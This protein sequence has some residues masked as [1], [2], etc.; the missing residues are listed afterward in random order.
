LAGTEQRGDR[1]T[2][3]VLA[4]WPLRLPDG[5]R[6]SMMSAVRVG[7]LL[8]NVGAA[9]SPQSIVEFAQTAEASGVA[10][11]W[12]G[13]HLLL[14]EQ[15]EARYPYND[16]GEYVVPSDRNFLDAFTTLAW[17]AGQTTAARLGVSV[18]IAPYR[19]PAQVAKVLGTL[20]FLAP[21]RVVFGVGT[22][23][24]RDEFD[25]LAVP[26]EDRNAATV[27][28][29]RFLR[30]AGQAEGPVT[31]DNVGYPSHRM[32]LRP[33]PSAGLP[34]W[35][36]G[37]G[38]LAR[39]RAARHGDAW[40]PALHR[41]SPAELAEQFDEVKALAVEA[42]RD[43]DSI[44]LTLF[45]GVALSDTWRERP[46]E[47]GMVRGPAEPVVETL[48]AYAEAGVSEFV[49]SIGGLDA[50]AVGDAR[51]ARPGGP[52]LRQPSGSRPWLIVDRPE[53]PTSTAGRR[54]GRLRA[55]RRPQL[56]PREVGSTRCARAAPS[57]RC[58]PQRWTVAAWWSSRMWSANSLATSSPRLVTW[59]L[60][61]IVLMWSFTVWREMHI[62]AAISLVD[63]PRARS[64]TTSD[65]RWV[66]P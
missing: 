32:F 35:I 45:V 9:A 16:S 6:R 3:A 44:E 1:G 25:S 18:C 60:E 29:V 62:S 53:S 36:G 24:M 65:S 46:W 7:A 49:L 51:R 57:E 20:E 34:I 59:H 56:R 41:Q 10:S 55:L 48:L 43:A 31:I 66:R 15:Q 17:V 8:P 26:F 52:A 28:L 11:L 61:K 40:H 14:A 2:I 13:D 54:G 63:S 4:S 50:P 64:G 19:H 58:A 30:H 27:R 39:K 5:R 22:G 33:Q 23:W 42:G 12:V 37:N 21:G 47:R 38:A